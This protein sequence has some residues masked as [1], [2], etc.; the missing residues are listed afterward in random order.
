MVYNLMLLLGVF[1]EPH[2]ITISPIVSMQRAWYETK[3][4]PF[5]SQL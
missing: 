1:I 3:N 2:Y 4:K 5:L